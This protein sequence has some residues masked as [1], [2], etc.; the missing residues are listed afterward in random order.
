MLI[1]CAQRQELSLRP[2]SDRAVYSIKVDDAT[3]IDLLRQQVHLDILKVQA[4]DVYF[5]A[6]N[7]DILKQL[8]SLGYGEPQSRSLDDVYML[9]GKVSGN[10]DEKEIRRLGVIVVNKEKD[11]LIVYGSLGR[12]K[13]VKKLGYD[14][15]QSDYEVRPREIEVKVKA[16]P[17]VQRI[18]DLGVDIFTAVKDS[19]GGFTI[20]GSA[21]DFQIDSINKMNYEVK[22]IKS[23]I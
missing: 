9:Y 20:Y 16:Q 6:D 12:L 23:K 2:P 14:L 8:T 18:Y 15:L 1:A 4:S 11:H 19:S 7:Q 21:F 17:D 3:E 10:Y 22:I 13:E 5:Y